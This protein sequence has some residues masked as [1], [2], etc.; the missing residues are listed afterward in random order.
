[1]STIRHE[2]KSGNRSN[3]ADHA[4]HHVIKIGRDEARSERRQAEASEAAQHTAKRCS[5]VTGLMSTQWRF[6]GAAACRGLGLVHVQVHRR[7][8]LA[9]KSCQHTPRTNLTCKHGP[10]CLLCL[11][12]AGAEGQVVGS[13]C[14]ASLWLLDQHLRKAVAVR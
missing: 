14:K 3:R 5:C 6:A 1:M 8:S 12:I 9:C 4:V 11:L 2:C 10:G 7:R 13:T